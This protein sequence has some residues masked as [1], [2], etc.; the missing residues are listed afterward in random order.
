MTDFIVVTT[1]DSESG[2]VFESCDARVIDRRMGVVRCDGNV[3]Q[4]YRRLSARGK[5]ALIAPLDGDCLFTGV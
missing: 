4:L 3:E 1:A 5:I 2:P